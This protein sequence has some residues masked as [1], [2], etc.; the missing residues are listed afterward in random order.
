[1]GIVKKWKDSSHKLNIVGEIQHL[2]KNYFL[3]VNS[4]G[5]MFLSLE[6]KEKLRAEIEEIEKSLKSKLSISSMMRGF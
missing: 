4:L 5:N 6:E 1:M 2:T 3:L